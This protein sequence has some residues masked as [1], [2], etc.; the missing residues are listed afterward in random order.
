ME[1][2][3]TPEREETKSTL[4]LTNASD[5]GKE[6]RE[7]GREGGSKGMRERQKE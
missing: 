6:G 4:K 1:R 7:K 3:N 2:E 5:G